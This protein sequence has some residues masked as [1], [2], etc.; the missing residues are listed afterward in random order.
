MVIVGISVGMENNYIK[1]DDECVIVVID[2]IGGGELIF[3]IF[4]VKGLNK[5]DVYFFFC[6][7]LG[8]IG[9]MKGIVIF[10]S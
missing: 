7:F 6:F 5:F 1:F 4:L 9:I 10:E 2:I 8:Y 3:I